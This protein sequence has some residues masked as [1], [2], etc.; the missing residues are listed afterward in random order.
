MTDVRIAEQ[1]YSVQGEGPYAGVPAIFLRLG[2]CNLVCGGRENIARD[3]DEMKPEGDATWVCD[4]IDVWRESD[5][6]EPKNLVDQWRSKGWLKYLEQGA[7]IVL[8]GGE[9]TLEYNQDAF[10]EFY[11]E[12]LE[13][14]Y[15]TFVEVETNGTREP[16]QYFAA[17]IDQFNV[18]LKLSNSGMSRDQRIHPEVIEY[19]KSIEEDTGA[20]VKFKF[21]ASREEDV[22]EIRNLIDEFDIPNSM[23]SLMPAGQT[24]ED[25]RNNYARVAELCKENGWMFSPRLQVDTWGEVTGV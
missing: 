11:A 1:F 25:M 3:K 16:G 19:Y 12:L 8:T 4:T 13:R 2:G 21:V 6:I 18:S 10:V 7:H 20:G 24:Q 14:G 15:K 22:E 9:P 23:I 17:Y 5:G